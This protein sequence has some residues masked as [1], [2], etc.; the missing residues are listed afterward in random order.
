VPPYGDYVQYIIAPARGLSPR[1]PGVA[2]GTF[3]VRADCDRGRQTCVTDG[4]FKAGRRWGWISI[5]K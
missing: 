1:T 5:K 4:N 2:I 3:Q